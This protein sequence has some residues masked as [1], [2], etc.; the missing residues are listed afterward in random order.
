MRSFHFLFL[1]FLLTALLSCKKN[2]VAPNPQPGPEPNPVG[3]VTPVGAPD[4][5]PVVSQTV[6]VAGGTVNSADGRLRVVIPSG[7]LSDDQT[8]S[9]TRITNHNPLGLRKAYRIL[10]HGLTFSKPVIIETR[11]EDEDVVNTLPDLLGIA[12]QNEEGIWRAQGGAV[13]NKNEKTVRITTTH[14]SD[15]S[16]FEKVHFAASAAQT[17]VNGSVSLE[18][19]TGEDLL[20]PLVAGKERSIGNRTSVLAKYITKWQLIGAGGL[21]VNGA[22]ATYAAPASVP[23]APN[24][25][26]VSVHLSLPS[27]GSFIVVHHITIVPDDGEIEVSVGG[28]PWVKKTASPAVK[29]G[30]LIL[31]G[32]SDGDIQ[33]SYVA[34]HVQEGVGTHAFKNPTAQSGTHVHY[35]I[36]GVENYTCFY[37]NSS[38]ELVASGGGVTITSMGETDG[39][40]RGTFSIDPAG[41]GDDLKSTIPIQGRFR[42]KKSW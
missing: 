13:V 4:G 7:A 33:G 41:F 17:I 39:F 23:G 3:V 8:I 9:I 37:S 12:Y 30:N 27:A 18:V 10:P 25:V 35:H 11:Y 34:I 14:F 16:L 19:F 15:W 1:A 38:G 31:I 2:P 36:T 5:S 42:V 6:G 20:E 28:G 22:S 24:P 29:M 40:I 32:D 21:G 26:A